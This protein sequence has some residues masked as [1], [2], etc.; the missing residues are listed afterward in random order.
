MKNQSLPQR[1]F[2][3]RLSL[4]QM[5]AAQWEALCD[6][7]GLCC[8]I[9]LED[10]DTGK[11]VP[12]CVSCAW[13]DTESGGCQDYAHRQKNVPECVALTPDLVAAFDWL[14]D[15][16]G[17]RRV[18]AGRDLAEWHPLK[19]GDPDSAKRH[20]QG[21][22][23]LPVVVKAHPHIDEQDYLLTSVSTQLPPT[24]LTE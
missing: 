1:P 17:Y 18:W 12:T 19:T 14:P 9:Q 5:D 6:G 16:C 2:W 8:L 4:S 20:A 22:H 3:Q 13:L 15:T 10:I 11:R 24:D 21:I 7:C 23:G